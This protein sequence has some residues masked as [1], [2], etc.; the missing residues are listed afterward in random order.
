MRRELE[1][2]GADPARVAAAAIAARLAAHPAQ[3]DEREPGTEVP[4]ADLL[5]LD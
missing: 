4:L 5:E 1:A 2:V 3:L